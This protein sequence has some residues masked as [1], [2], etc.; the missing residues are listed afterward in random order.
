MD[1]S[2]MNKDNSDNH[3]HNDNQSIKERDKKELHQCND[4][5]ILIIVD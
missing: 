1:S 2:N 3:K 4:T 5:V